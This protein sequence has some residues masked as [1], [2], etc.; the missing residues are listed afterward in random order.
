MSVQARIQLKIP[1]LQVLYEVDFSLDKPKQCWDAAKQK[2][3]YEVWLIVRSYS[4][5]REFTEDS[6]NLFFL[7]LIGYDIG[8]SYQHFSVHQLLEARSPSYTSFSHN[9]GFCATIRVLIGD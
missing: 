9:H 5:L 6:E 4:L 2:H 1:T 8:R 7:F 3:V